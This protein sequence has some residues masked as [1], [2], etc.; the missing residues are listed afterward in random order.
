LNRCKTYFCHKSNVY[1][2]NNIWQTEM[3]IA[4]S[5]VSEPSF[6]DVEIAAEKLRRYK[7]P[8]TEK[9]PAELMQAVGK[10]C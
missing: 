7:S 8:D 6:F 10:M 1:G 4:G 2:P 5:L 3:H 9:I